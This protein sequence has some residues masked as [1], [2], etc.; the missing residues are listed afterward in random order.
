MRVSI[1]ALFILSVFIG[2]VLEVP[3]VSEA[4]RLRRTLLIACLAVGTFGAVAE[5][6][7][8]IKNTPEV[9][10]IYSPIW[11]QPIGFRYQ[12]YGNQRSPLFR[13]VFK[14]SNN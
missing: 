2:R 8:T 11:E 12:Y 6:S 13:A 7:R 4:E 9:R 14:T 3:L 5:I 1:P 10:P